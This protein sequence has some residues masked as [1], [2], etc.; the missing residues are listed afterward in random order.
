MALDDQISLTLYD[1]IFA[2]IGGSDPDSGLPSAF[3]SVS[4]ML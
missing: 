4:T 3:D 1:R 2:V